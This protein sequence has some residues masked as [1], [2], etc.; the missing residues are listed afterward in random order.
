MWSLLEALMTPPEQ[1]VQA[2]QERRSLGRV[3]RRKTG[4]LCLGVGRGPNAA[5]AANAVRAAHREPMNAN[6]ITRASV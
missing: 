5:P 3:G 6:A 4:V 2:V 1:I